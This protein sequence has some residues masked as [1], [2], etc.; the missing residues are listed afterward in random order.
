M[1][2]LINKRD[3]VRSQVRTVWHCKTSEGFQ[4]SAVARCC[5]CCRAGRTIAVTSCVHDRQCS[6]LLCV[7]TWKTSM[8]H[9][10]VAGLLAVCFYLCEKAA[11]SCM[12]SFSDDFDTPTRFGKSYT[13]PTW[14]ESGHEKE[15][16]VTSTKP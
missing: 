8:A 4:N 11:H 7:Q 3:V 9:S 1:M 5:H 16:R 6:H 15:K 12:P 10:K 13:A 14:N 2:C